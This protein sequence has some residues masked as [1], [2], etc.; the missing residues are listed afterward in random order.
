MEEPRLRRAALL[1][2]IAEG[3]VATA[4]PLLATAVSRDP[5]AIAGV[6]AAQH[7]PWI[8]VALAWPL[9]RRTDRRTVV[10]L[11]HTMRALA[12]AYLGFHAMASTENIFK[13]QL[14][15]LI[16]GLGEA[17][18]GSVEDEAGDSRLSTRGMWGV[19]LVGMPLGG[20][21]YEIFAAVPF[22]M[23]VLFFALAAL[24]A[25]FVPR[26]V[27]APAAAERPTVPRLA[28]GTGGVALT[29]LLASAA[30]A[31]VLGVLVLFAI[32]DLG[33]GAPAFGVLLAGIAAATAAGGF[34]A[35]ETGSA[36][37]LKAG[38][39]VSSIV[40]GAALVTA[41]RVADA[42]RPWASAL[43][44]GIA[45]ATATT[46]AVL[47]RALLP[48]AAGRPVTGSALRAFHLAEWVGL[49][50]GALA[51]GWWARDHGVADAIQLAAGGW[52]G[53]A[54]V[55]LFVRRR[56]ASSLAEDSPNKW[57]DAA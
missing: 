24:F 48:A 33:L 38:F 49:C 36:L 44:L 37:G 31:A 27:A 14:V 13:I 46:G 35:P 30:R 17:L 10:G 39:V 26:A 18:S 8:L 21:L 23:D 1:A 15:A 25:L 22:L 51:A 4:L 55:V 47:L 50:A 54:I 3:V 52:A 56:A 6:V 20:F 32:V 42:E 7:G 28:K 43:A 41:A 34:I 12:I 45:W 2:G 5:L 29:A 9:V 40:S 16:V 57:L 11:V 19:A 53:A